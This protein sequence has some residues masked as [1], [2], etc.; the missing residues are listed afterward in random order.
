MKLKKRIFESRLNGRPLELKWHMFKKFRTA[1]VNLLLQYGVI[2]H[3]D[4]SSS[5][6]N[7]STDELI[8]VMNDLISINGLEYAIGQRVIFSNLYI[9]GIIEVIKGNHNG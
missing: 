9:N 4:L 8:F 1:Q 7:C 6:L 2:K 3:D 5:P